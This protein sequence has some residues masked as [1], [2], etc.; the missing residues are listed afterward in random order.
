MLLLSSYFLANGVRDNFANDAEYIREGDVIM[1]TAVRRLCD[2]D[3]LGR[4]RAEIAIAIISLS[5]SV[6]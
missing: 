6:N 4:A 3:D 1:V 5:A 2:N